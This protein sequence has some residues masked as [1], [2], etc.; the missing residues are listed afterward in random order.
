MSSRL[1]V[2]F[3]VL[4]VVV[5]IALREGPREIARWYHAAAENA[6]DRDEREE[7]ERL[8]TRALDF[9]P[10]DSALLVRRA[11]LRAELGRRS[12]ALDDLEQA[13]EGVTDRERLVILPFRAAVYQELRLW[14]KALEDWK[15]VER[16]SKIHGPIYSESDLLNNLAYARALAETEL[17]QAFLD[18]QTSVRLQPNPH[19]R[20][21]LGYVL[22]Q[23]QNPLAALEELN[24]AVAAAEKQYA[25]WK[26]AATKPGQQPVGLRRLER[27]DEARRK[28]L[29][30]MLYHRAL[31]NELLDP[32]QAEADYER[33]RK[34]L[35]FEP[36]PHLF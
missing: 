35:R 12:D 20:D 7:A 17:D 6:V 9:A 22:Y 34:E 29:A 4:M 16:L 32:E 36:G 15:E 19:N 26:Q 33:I 23:R 28:M 3:M 30:V 1:A 25:A 24:A 5:P 21:T 18:A 2:L 8:L 31:V 11:Q 14:D 13:V 27:E 10:G